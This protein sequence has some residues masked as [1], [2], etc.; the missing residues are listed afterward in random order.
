MFY[1]YFIIALQIFC[2]YHIYKNRNPY[3]WVFLILFVPLIGSIIY[4]FRYVFNSADTKKVQKD[5]T[6]TINPTKKTKDLERKLQF[7]DTYANRIEL[8]DAYYNNKNFVSAIS[9]YKKSLEDTVQDDLYAQQML[10]LSY[11]QLH[12]YE[13]VVKHSE[14]ILNKPEFKGSKQQF[15]YG[16]A[17][18]ELGKMEEAEHQLKQIDKPYSNYTQ[19]LELAKFYLE[20]NKINEGKSLLE[21]ISVESKNMTKPNRRIYSTTIAEVERLLKSL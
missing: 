3:Y 20:T 7:S 18:K 16:M 6:N 14:N 12:N 13:N 21:E 10:I 2:F 1:Y 19:R 15:C 5:I 11:Y 8:A 9:N 17:L 4:L